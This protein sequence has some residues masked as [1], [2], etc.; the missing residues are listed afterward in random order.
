MKTFKVL[1]ALLSYPTEALI[2]AAPEFAAVLDAERLVPA[3]CRGTVDVL[4][5]E[6]AIGDLYDLQERYGL[7]FDRSKTLALHLFEHV[8]G[9]SRD[10]GQ[11]MVDLK[12][13][14][15]NAGLAIAANE[16]PDYVPLFLEFLATQPFAEARELLGQTAHIF[17][18]L[19]ERLGRRESSYK[20]V[21]DALVKIAAEAPR[22][23]IVDELLKAPETDPMDLVALDAAW[24]EEEV[25]FGPGAQGQSA[26]GHETLIARLRHARRAV[27]P[28]P[29]HPQ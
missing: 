27:G 11:A 14:Y 18:A 2:E 17:A 10:R 23:D 26:C 1:S 4:I 28:A 16:L 13:M 12:A 24:E 9:E 7:L 19:A 20:G 8:H 5:E 29:S 22:R 6:I 21:F 25:R 3:A 15:E